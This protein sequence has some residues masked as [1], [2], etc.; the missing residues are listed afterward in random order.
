MLK[1]Y[2]ETDKESPNIVY[3]RIR[4]VRNWDEYPFSGKLSREQ[5]GEMVN[6]LA[7]GMREFCLE[8]V[9]TISPRTHLSFF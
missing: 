5:A 4:L 3:S 7:R 8:D 1:W 9:K 6:R 2:E